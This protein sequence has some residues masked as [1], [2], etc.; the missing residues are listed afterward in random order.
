MV[1]SEAHVV[2]DDN[3]SQWNNERV[4]EEQQYQA[5]IEWQRRAAAA[6]AAEKEK[7]DAEEAE[8]KRG[9]VASEKAESERDSSSGAGR[10]ETICDRDDAKL[11]ERV[12]ETGLK[13]YSSGYGTYLM[14]KLAVERTQRCKDS[15]RTQ[16]DYYRD[17]V[18][19]IRKFEQECGGEIRDDRYECRFNEEDRKY[20]DFL[21][22]EQSILLHDPNYSA[23]LGG[24]GGVAR[25]SSQ[26]ERALDEQEEK[27]RN[28]KNNPETSGSVVAATQRAMFLAS[29]RIRVIKTMCADNPGYMGE[30]PGIEAGYK[31]AEKMC[32]ALSGDPGAC[33]P[34]LN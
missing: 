21:S 23:S 11:L 25:G 26:C 20:I 28:L 5:A 32:L 10:Y 9:D 17:A 6:A 7:R 34:V 12:H 18:D 22:R 33:R 27:Y 30:I 19:G 31:G 29:E 1:Q 14:H 15:S 2:P 24:I 13:F 8:R 4:A 3:L 16:M